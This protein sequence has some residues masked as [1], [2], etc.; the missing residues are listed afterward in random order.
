[1]RHLIEGVWTWKKKL[2]KEEKTQEKKQIEQRCK[3]PGYQKWKLAGSHVW[4]R[5]EMLS[6]KEVCDKN[7]NIW[8]PDT[9]TLR[10][11]NIENNEVIPC[12]KNITC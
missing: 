11:L 3:P 5:L 7:K 8:E 10:F 9:S 6:E 2:M 12:R 4:E 1:M